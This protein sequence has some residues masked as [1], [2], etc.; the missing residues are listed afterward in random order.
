MFGEKGQR[1]AGVVDLFQADHAAE[2]AFA[3]AAAA[4]VETERDVAEVVQ[5]LRR[6]QHVGGILV[7]AEAVQHEKRGAPLA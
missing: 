4:H 1:V 6:L 3:V 5:H 2:F 7:A